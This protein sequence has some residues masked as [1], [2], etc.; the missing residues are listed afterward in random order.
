MVIGITLGDP[1]GIG[2]EIAIKACLDKSLRK[3]CI[4]LLIGSSDFIK[5][6][7][8]SILKL[9][10]QTNEVSKKEDLSLDPQVLNVYNVSSLKLKQI[11]FGKDSALG[12]KES[13]LYLDT[14]LKLLKDGLI[15]AVTTCPIS[16]KS[17][18]LAGSNFPGHTEYFAA[19]TET[20]KYVMA[21][22]SKRLKLALVTWHIPLSKVSQVLTKEK[23]L[24]VLEIVSKSLPLFGKKQNYKIGVCGFNPHAGEHSLLGQEEANII[25]PAIMEF[26][27]K[28]VT[29]KGPFPSDTLFVGEHMKEF[30]FI[31][32]MYH[33]QGL[34]PFKMLAFDCGVNV[35]LGLPIVRTSVDHGTA[36]DI[37]GKGIA[38]EKSL[39]E[40]I[41]LAE[42]M[43][44]KV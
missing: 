6:T 42:K 14:S 16:K 18:N 31:V 36:F 37:A 7:G 1:A 4:P 40:A 15:D 30:D 26:Q 12:G 3:K 22:Y 43:V 33:D 17:L 2:A 38:N 35:T 28:G 27:K 44:K 9:Y 10:F 19:K 21:F 8:N 32:A 41:M 29:V 34:I 25:A 13:L 23:I 20:K 39:K 24:D 5:Q 11:K